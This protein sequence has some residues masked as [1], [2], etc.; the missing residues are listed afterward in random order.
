MY[1]S[2]SVWPLVVTYKKV[3]SKWPSGFLNMQKFSIEKSTNLNAQ[4][5]KKL[6]KMR[7]S[8][9]SSLFT[10][11]RCGLNWF[12]E[13]A[14]WLAGDHWVAFWLAKSAIDARAPSSASINLKSLLRMIG[15]KF[16]VT[17]ILVSG[18]NRSEFLLN[19]KLRF[20][21]TFRRSNKTNLFE[22]QA[23]VWHKLHLFKCLGQF[24]CN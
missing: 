23:Q 24:Q 19:L 6:D 5:C 18:F 9:P 10:G 12:F 21:G 16:R 17:S 20:R 8:R 1:F 3:K 22:N 11:L 14:L 2:F 4:V 13:D 15:R 7:I